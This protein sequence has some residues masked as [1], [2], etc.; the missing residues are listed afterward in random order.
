MTTASA[1]DDNDNDGDDDEAMILFVSRSMILRFFRVR[2][3]HIQFESGSSMLSAIAS[4]S[5]WLADWLG[6]IVIRYNSNV[7][8]CKIIG[9]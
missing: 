1:N 9:R 7:A 5:G 4:A 2:S 6:H 8:D 3:L